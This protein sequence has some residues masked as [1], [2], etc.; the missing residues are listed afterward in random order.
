MGKQILS[1]RDVAPKEFNNTYGTNI[2]TVTNFND[3]K[4]HYH[5][6]V[7]ELDKHEVSYFYISLNSGDVTQ[8]IE[9]EFELAQCLKVEVIRILPYTIVAIY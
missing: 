4:G 3:I 2:K 7:G 5:N 1:I 9:D 6:V 8:A